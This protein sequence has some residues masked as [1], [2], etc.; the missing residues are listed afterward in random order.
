MKP[1]LV[2]IALG[3]R[4]APVDSGKDGVEVVD[5][6]TFIADHSAAWCGWMATCE[7]DLY[8]ATWATAQACVDDQVAAWGDILAEAEAEHG[9][10]VP[11]PERSATCLST[12]DGASCADGDSIDQDCGAIWACDG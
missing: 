3:C 4:S 2:I 1:W 5:S 6:D 11:D 8:D 12:L 9:T 7:P 10:C